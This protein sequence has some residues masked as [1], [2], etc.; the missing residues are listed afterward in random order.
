MDSS[1]IDVTGSCS[2]STLNGVKIGD[3]LLQT[4]AASGNR[5]IKFVLGYT[6]FDGG[7]NLPLDNYVEVIDQL[8][9]LIIKILVHVQGNI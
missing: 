6:L 1:G 3:E 8:M 4:A 2:H 7:G 9:N 5:I